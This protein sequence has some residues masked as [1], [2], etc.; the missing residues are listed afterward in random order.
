M[1]DLGRLSGIDQP[2]DVC[3]KLIAEGVL[4]ELPISAQRH[5]VWHHQVLEEMC[6]RIESSLDKMHDRE[7]LR[8]TVDRS[9]LTHQL[10]YCLDA[11]VLDHLLRQMEKAKRVRRLTDRGVGLAGRGPQLSKSESQLLADLII[12]FKEAGFQPP[13][14]KECEATVTKNRASVAS[15]VRLAATEGELVEV[16]ANFYLHHEVERQMRELL[17]KEITASGGL[18]L[19]QIRELLA[20]TRKYAVPICEYLDRIGFTKRDGDLRLLASVP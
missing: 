10:S 11:P 16:A 14:I 17:T 19:S 8:S 7:P 18:T 12:K 20:T 5:L 2:A 4:V 15:L 9:R 1:V 3:R 6:Q 13:T